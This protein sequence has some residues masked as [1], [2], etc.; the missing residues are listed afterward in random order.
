M[1]AIASQ[2]LQYRDGV[3]DA[4][5]ARHR[6]HVFIATWVATPAVVLL[7]FTGVLFYF[8]GTIIAVW[9]TALSVESLPT[10]ALW[11][12][13]SIAAFLAGNGIMV[14][15]DWIERTFI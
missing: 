13:A 3:D 6:T 14:L 7:A 5:I 10:A 8:A 12:L 9:A 2:P 1:S 11:I 4:L 15:A